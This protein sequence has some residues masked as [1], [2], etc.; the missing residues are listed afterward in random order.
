MYIHAGELFSHIFFEIIFI[1]HQRSEVK[2]QI[3]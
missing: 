2:L 1:E 3:I